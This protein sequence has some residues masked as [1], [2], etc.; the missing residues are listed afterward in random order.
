MANALF[1]PG[2]QR[3]VDSRTG[4]EDRDARIIIPVS[5]EQEPVDATLQM[6]LDTGATWCVLPWE[7]AEAVGIPVG[8]G[9]AAPLETRFGRLEGEWHRHTLVLRG[10]PDLCEDDFELRVDATIWISKRWP[11]NLGYDGIIGYNGCL[12]RIRFAV[13]P[14]ETLFYFGSTEVDGE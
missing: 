9:T 6:A 1:G 7:I 13:D 2:A 5:I 10:D 8:Q 4:F 11:E 14:S 3:Y 12:E